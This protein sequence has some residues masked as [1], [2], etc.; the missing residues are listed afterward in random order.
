MRLLLS[1]PQVLVVAAW[2]AKGGAG[3]RCAAGHAR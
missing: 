3:A 2:R 1:L